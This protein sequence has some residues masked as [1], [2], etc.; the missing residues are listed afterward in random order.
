MKES[1]AE[2]IHAAQST[3]VDTAPCGGMMRRRRRDG[4]RPRPH[5]ILRGPSGSAARRRVRL[6]VY[7]SIPEQMAVARQIATLFAQRVNFETKD[8]STGVWIRDPGRVW[9]S[10]MPDD[11][12]VEAVIDVAQSPSSSSYTPA[13]ASARQC[14][15]CKSRTGRAGRDGDAATCWVDYFRRLDR[16]CQD[17][18]PNGGIRTSTCPP[19]QT[20]GPASTSK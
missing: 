5:A 3:K 19:A 6:I 4:K 17:A 11:V 16:T 7:W 1:I 15:A 9:A 20:G 18:S 14:R 12:R 13:R 10:T 2:R 8:D